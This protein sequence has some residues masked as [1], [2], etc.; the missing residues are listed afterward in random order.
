MSVPKSTPPSATPPSTTPPTDLTPDPA[1][2]SVP[3]SAPVPGRT[4]SPPNIKA[5]SN[6]ITVQEMGDEWRE[7]HAQ[8]SEGFQKVS[9]LFSEMRFLLE[10]LNAQIEA[11]GKKS[12]LGDVLSELD[13]FNKDN[14]TANAHLAALGTHMEK[15]K[16]DGD[17]DNLNEEGKKTL[18]NFT[19]K[20]TQASH[21]YN[22]LINDAQPQGN[23]NPHL[24]SRTNNQAQTDSDTNAM[25]DL[26]AEQAKSFKKLADSLEKQ[27][28]EHENSIKELREIFE[29]NFNNQVEKQNDI[30]ERLDGLIEEFSQKNFENSTLLRGLQNDVKTQKENAQKIPSDQPKEAKI[31]ARININVLPDFE[32]LCEIIDESELGQDS[33]NALIGFLTKLPMVISNDEIKRVNE[34]LTDYAHMATNFPEKTAKFKKVESA[35]LKIKEIRSSNPF[36]NPI[37]NPYTS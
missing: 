22:S 12:G 6:S 7:A 1:L 28:T 35:I 8:I 32:S 18:Q 33:Q 27:K 5:K 30:E 36:L 24:K 2:P 20:L 19:E 37:K 23:T 14:S 16:T 17:F 15:M 29:E 11:T 10:S 13:K 26:L 9:V 3:G 34:I 21:I 4:D 31:K 25:S